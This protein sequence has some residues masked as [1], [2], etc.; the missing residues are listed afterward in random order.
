MRLS[1]F[2]WYPP[3]K[4]P[5]ANAWGEINKPT[6]IG[7]TK[8]PPFERVPTESF[9][10][11]LD[12]STRFLRVKT[13]KKLLVIKIFY[14]RCIICEISLGELSTWTFCPVDKVNQ[15]PFFSPFV[16]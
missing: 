10:T 1:G 6:E 16:N 3:I 13:R 5:Q 4:K 12:K 2:S 9:P 8:N 7:T 14:N 15:V 11:S